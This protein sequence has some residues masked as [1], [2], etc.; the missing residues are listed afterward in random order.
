VKA[1]QVNSFL[2]LVDFIVIFL[3]FFFFFLGGRGGVVFFFFCGVG[4][5]PN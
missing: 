3:L 5:F 1:P 4:F 2:F